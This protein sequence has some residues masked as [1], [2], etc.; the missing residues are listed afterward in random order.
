[1]KNIK[2]K[3][4]LTISH[5]FTRFVAVGIVNTAVDFGFFIL[6]FYFF[7]WHA[8]PSNILA[9]LV[10][11]LQSYALNK[12]WAFRHDGNLKVNLKEYLSFLGATLLSVIVSTSIIFFGQSY[13]EPIVLKLAAAIINPFL[14]YFMYQFIFRRSNQAITQSQQ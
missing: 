3:L 9:F 7:N 1:M 12:Y 5:S 4:K 13:A 14:N 6:L 11:N 8:V 2:Q 10:A